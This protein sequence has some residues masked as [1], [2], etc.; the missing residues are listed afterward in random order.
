M[1]MKILIID[2]ETTGFIPEGHSI[3]EIGIVLCDSDT[4]ITTPVF[5]QVIR[6]DEWDYNKH[7]NAWIFRNTDLTPE[8]VSKAKHINHYREELQNLFN[9]Y[10]I[11]AY[12]KRFDVSFMT[13]RGFKLW[14]TKDLQENAKDIA[15]TYTGSRRPPSVEKLHRWFFPERNYIETHRGLDDAM[16]EAEIFYKF[17][18]MKAGKDVKIVL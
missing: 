15:Q 7:R 18:D 17:C 2:I 12:N 4:R 10:L 11:T 16:H 6:D 14:D 3:V 13:A 1:V 8:Q 9:K 5:N